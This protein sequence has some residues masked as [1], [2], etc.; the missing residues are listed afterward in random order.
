M[1]SNDSAL[2]SDTDL[3][4]V[5]ITRIYEAPRE[6]V[7]ACMTT[8]EH[9]THFW[10]PPG[11]STPLDSIVIELHVGGRFET[12][13]V[14]DANGDRY[15]TSG[16]YV[17]IDPPSKLVWSESGAAE[18]MMTISTFIDL[19]NDR[20]EVVIHQQ[21]VPAF[22]RSPEALAGFNASLD[23]FAEYLASLR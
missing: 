10:G 3:G 19:G 14:N 16:I 21:N 11:V 13:M 4:E 22:F 23:R 7:F 20:T 9:L 18:G 2:G 15:P 1:S 17:E 12:V 6:L 8:P 5:V